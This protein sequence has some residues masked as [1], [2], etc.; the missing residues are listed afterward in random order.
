[1]L[2]IRCQPV[3][4]QIWRHLEMR[5]AWILFRLMPSVDLALTHR[6]EERILTD[7]AAKL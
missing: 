6:R 7:K 2:D 3:K 1:M 5:N 4:I